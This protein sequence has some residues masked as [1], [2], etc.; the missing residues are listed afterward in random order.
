M[1]L[2]FIVYTVTALVLFW[3]GMHVSERESRLKS[4]TGLA[5]P[6]WSWEIVAGIAFFALMLGL[7]YNTGGDYMMYMH[8]FHDV[9]ATGVFSRHD[10]EPGFY[11]ITLLIAKLG[12]PYQ[13]YFAFW[14]LVEGV[15]LYFGLRNHKFLIPWFMVLLFLGP[16][17]FDFMTF[18]RQWVVA[19]IF[20]CM[21]PLIVNRKFCVYA[22]ITVVLASIH[23]SALLFLALYFVPIIIKGTGSRKLYVAIF[24]CSVV[25]GIWPFW[26]KFLGFFVDLIDWVGYGKYTRHIVDV[27][28]GQYRGIAWGPLH[29]IGVIS[30]L[31]FIYYYPQVRDHFKHNRL[32]PVFFAIALAGACYENLMMNTYVAFL[33]PAELTYAI[34]LV[35]LSYTCTYLYQT[36]QFKQLALCLIIPCSYMYIDLIKIHYLYND[37]YDY[38]Y[39]NFITM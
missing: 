2:S 32:I 19:I 28:N 10:F 37:I 25:I 4:A 5:L 6:L 1:V 39:Y 16:Y 36:R 11:L 31:L 34:I 33:R 30:E 13:L 23:R 29:L 26:F 8:Q 35:M 9:Q 21:V 3:L 12:A 7:R 18:M 15:F 14:A 38:C 20:V 27:V 17:C 22:L 24:L